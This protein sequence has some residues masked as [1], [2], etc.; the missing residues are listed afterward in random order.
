MVKLEDLTKDFSIADGAK[1]VAFDCINLISENYGDDPAIANAMIKGVRYYL[2]YLV[3][4]GA[5][6]KIDDEDDKEENNNEKTP[7]FKV[8]QCFYIDHTEQINSHMTA[9]RLRGRYEILE[10]GEV[11]GEVYYKI[12][13]NIDGR[14]YGDIVFVKENVLERSEIQR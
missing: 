13:Q 3:Q 2:G 14:T 7:K 12:L 6:A 10:V 4:A 1:A 11:N 8:G 9:Q 5:F